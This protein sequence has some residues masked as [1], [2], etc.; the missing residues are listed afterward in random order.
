M[1]KL[2]KIANALDQI[3]K[4]AGVIWLIAAAMTF[5]IAVVSIFQP[6]S[7]FRNMNTILSLGSVKVDLLPD[8][9]PSLAFVRM[10]SVLGGLLLSVLG[11]FVFY[12]TKIIRKILA[13]M[14]SELPFDGEIHKN[15]RKLGNLT[16]I[17]GT[18]YNIVKMFIESVVYQAYQ[19]PDLF[20]TEKIAGCRLE[21]K[22]DFTFV[23]A[24]VIILML[25]YVF[26]YGAE[27]QQQSDETL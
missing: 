11:L 3:A 9:C 19:I 23:I 13:P 18:A 7:A 15:L 20:L 27:L 26:Q 24:G 22:A 6:E 5:F 17:Y 12:V 14:K 2:S 25:S 10:R 4:V 8:Y 1:G 21:L 16:W